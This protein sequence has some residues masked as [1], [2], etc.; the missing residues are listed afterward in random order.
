MSLP[1]LRASPRQDPKRRASKPEKLAAILGPNFR[2]GLNPGHHPTVSQNAP[3]IPHNG[4][5]SV[6]VHPAAP[7]AQQQGIPK[8]WQGYL[9]PNPP[10]H[11]QLLH[12]K[13]PPRADGYLPINRSGRDY[14][15]PIVTLAVFGG[16]YTEF[17]INKLRNNPRVADLDPDFARDF[18][19]SELLRLAQNWSE[20]ATPLTF[21]TFD[22]YQQR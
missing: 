19:V 9:N 10:T 3:V 14:N 15:C 5:N 8:P 20:P 2:Y 13:R 1:F 22:D 21:V 17:I 16:T 18:Y 4:A 6:N 11:L 12:D 7:Y